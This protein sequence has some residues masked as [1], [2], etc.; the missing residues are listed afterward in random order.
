QHASYDFRDDRRG[1]NGSQAHGGGI[2]R[3]PSDHFEERRKDGPHT[4][5]RAGDCGSLTPDSE[6]PAGRSTG[7]ELRNR[8]ASDPRSP[9][10]PFAAAAFRKRDSTRSGKG[11]GYVRDRFPGAAGAGPAASY[12]AE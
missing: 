3:I 1:T 4:G 8:T 2:G 6:A 5:G 12:I 10:L 7:A 9:G 11:R